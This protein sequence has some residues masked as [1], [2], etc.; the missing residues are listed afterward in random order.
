LL[1]NCGEVSFDDVI[2]D[3]IASDNGFSRTR[4]NSNS[5]NEFKANNELKI[6]KANETNEIYAI[7]MKKDFSGAE[8]YAIMLPPKPKK[9]FLVSLGGNIIKRPFIY[10]NFIFVISSAGEDFVLRKINA[11]SGIVSWIINL[12]ERVA[13]ESLIA[14]TVSGKIFVFYSDKILVLE[15]KDTTESN[16]GNNSGTITPPK[17]SYEVKINSKITSLPFVSNGKIFFSTQSS[18]YSIAF[19]FGKKAEEA[20]VTEEIKHHSSFSVLFSDG[21]YVVA[22]NKEGKVVGYDLAE[23]RHLW[24]FRTGGEIVTVADA[25]DSVLVG[26]LDNYC[27]LFRKKDGKIL[28]KLRLP[29]RVSH[30]L[31]IGNSDKI[32]WHDPTDDSLNLMD[33]R[34]GDVES[35]F[36][37]SERLMYLGRLDNNLIYSVSRGRVLFFSY[38]RCPG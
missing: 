38:G 3:V 6:N 16:T 26:S 9:S 31:S 4:T 13:P 23:K 25:K 37:L 36:V 34:S 32:L 7:S 35:K 19:S 29:S 1:I 24:T 21:K 30:F 28:R 15:E 18:I 2:Y 33:V 5:N 22:G 27:Y 11:N 17:T 12:K 8:I 20:V 10:G 14:N